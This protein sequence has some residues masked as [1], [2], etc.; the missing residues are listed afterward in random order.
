MGGRFVR[1]LPRPGI[2]PLAERER[3]IQDLVGPGGVRAERL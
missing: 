1:R 2:D 3:G